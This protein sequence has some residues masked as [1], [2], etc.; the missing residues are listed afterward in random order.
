VQRRLARLRAGLH[1]A[2]G[3]RADRGDAVEGSAWAT[4]ATSATSWA[5]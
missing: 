2:A 5:R 4:C 3:A 1:L